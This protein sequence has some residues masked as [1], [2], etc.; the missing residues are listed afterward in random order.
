TAVVADEEAL[1]VVGPGGFVH[2]GGALHALVGGEIAD[3][4]LVELE[5]HLLVE[6]HGVELARGR[7]G[8]VDDGRGHP[9]AVQIEEAH[10]LARVPDL[11]G[12]RLKGSRLAAKGAGD[13]D[14]GDGLRRL[15]EAP[16][17]PGLEDAHDPSVLSR[18]ISSAST[19]NWVT[20]AVPA[21]AVRF[22]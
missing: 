19:R 17:R 10:V 20:G 12:H 3:V 15:L 13:V 18:W 16:H 6:G 8:G 9:M 11:P 22:G 14:D 1:V 5:P 2:G 4:V 21:S 7:E